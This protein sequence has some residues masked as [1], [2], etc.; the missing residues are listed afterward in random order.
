MRGLRLAGEALGGRRRA[1]RGKKSV[2]SVRSVPNTL[3]RNR[4][5]ENDDLLFSGSDQK[6]LEIP[7]PDEDKPSQDKKSRSRSLHSD[8]IR[9]GSLLSEEQQVHSEGPLNRQ[10][11]PGRKHPCLEGNAQAQ[12]TG[13]GLLVLDQDDEPS[14]LQSAWISNQLH[15]E[16]LE[17]QVYFYCCRYWQ[18][19]EECAVHE[20]LA[21]NRDI[22]DQ[23]K[24]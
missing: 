3:L 21:Y 23:E 2:K 7:D 6:M 8:Q 1:R 9:Q 15:L 5:F 10:L 22:L 18:L 11:L 16:N 14:P 13:G 24:K 17:E 20:C 19:Q 4:P 12:A